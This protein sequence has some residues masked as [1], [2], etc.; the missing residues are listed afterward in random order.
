MSTLFEMGS[1]RFQRAS[2]GILPDESFPRDEWLRQDAEA[3]TLEACAPQI[4]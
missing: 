2:S 1:A 4:P 3:R